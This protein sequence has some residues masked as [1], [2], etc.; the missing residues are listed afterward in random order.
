A[1][2]VERLIGF[3]L[4]LRRE[5]YA[6][7]GALDERFGLGFFE[8]DDLSVR[9]RQAGFRLLVALDVFI[10]HFGSR[11]FAG[12]GIDGHSQLRENFE[13][14]RD[15]WGAERTAGYRLPEPAQRRERSAERGVKSETN[16]EESRVGVS[17]CMIVRN[18]EANLGLC[19]RSVADLVDE[20]IVVDTGSTDR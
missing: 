8:D 10:H 16:T 9:A 5:A 20:I 4:L 7:V 13:K 2:E 17:L 3:C 1:L 6:A 19:L 18:E 12:L 11:T 14:F 15:K